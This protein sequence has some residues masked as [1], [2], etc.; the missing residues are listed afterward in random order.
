MSL[1][2]PVDAHLELAKQEV[3]NGLE[4]ALRSAT[5]AGVISLMP[6]IGSAIQNLLDGKA[7]QNVDRRRLELFVE[8]RKRIEEIRR[9]QIPD[10]QCLCARVGEPFAQVFGHELG[11]VV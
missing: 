5:I 11:P 4:E 6:G 10:V 2:D 9:S 3:D 1:N 8:M 7:R